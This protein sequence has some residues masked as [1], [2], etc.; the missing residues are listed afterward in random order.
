MKLATPLT[1]A[2]ASAGRAAVLKAAGI[3]FVQVPATV[4]EAAIRE[5]LRADG[6]PPADQADLL[7]ETKAVRVSAGRAGVVLGADQMLAC[8]GEAFDKPR[9]MAEA[10]DQLKRLRGRTHMLETAL[11][12]AVEGAPVW[13]HLA[14]PRLRMRAFSDAFLDAYLAAVGE[15][16]LTTVGAYKLEGLGVHL[17]E[18]VDGE[19][20][21]IIGL[22]LLPLL[23]WLR[24]RG[25]LP[26]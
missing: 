22:P 20:S 1:L 16:A 23:A 19:Q 9:S 21:A 25:D 17:F 11:V 7:A 6:R 5:A 8:E 14:R 12:A 26:A 24:D 4:D 2:S 13:R 15:D 10:R 3:D 18:R